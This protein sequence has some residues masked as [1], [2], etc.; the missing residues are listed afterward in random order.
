PM[1]EEFSSKLGFDATEALKTFQLLE[2][3]V[4]SYTQ[5]LAANQAITARFNKGQQS[6]DNVLKNIGKTASVVA[7]AFEKLA[8]AQ[9]KANAEAQRQA[10]NAK[11]GRQ[12]DARRR[13][14]EIQRGV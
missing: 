12:L 14:V 8:A 13:A 3:V 10:Q 6:S 11:T 4:T 5:A 7:S 9:A 1:A 2:T